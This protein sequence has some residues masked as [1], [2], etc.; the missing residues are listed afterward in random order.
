MV[1]RGRAAVRLT[2]LSGL[3]RLLSP[4]GL[5]PQAP[6]QR[7][8]ASLV[9]PARQAATDHELFV[10]LLTSRSDS[11]RRDFSREISLLRALA[12]RPGV[13]KL[14][15]AS[16]DDRLLFHACERVR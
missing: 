8:P 14:R 2:S 12:G 5:L 4:H 10:K 16:D 3:E 9:F 6:V 13:K 7:R 1:A 11:A 15:V